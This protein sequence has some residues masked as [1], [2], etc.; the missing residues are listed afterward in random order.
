MDTEE[1]SIN[2]SLPGAKVN[3]IYSIHSIRKH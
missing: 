3:L 2:T 1:N